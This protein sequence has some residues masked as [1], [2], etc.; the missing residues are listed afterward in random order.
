MNEGLSGNVEEMYPTLWERRRVAVPVKVSMLG[1]WKGGGFRVL[2]LIGYVS[3]SFCGLIEHKLGRGEE[4]GLR[5]ST[6]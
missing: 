2:V 4:H 5:S 6:R 3:E 1:C